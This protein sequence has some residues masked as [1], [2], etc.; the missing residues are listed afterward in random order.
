MKTSQADQWRKLADILD[1]IDRRGLRVLSAEE[2]L[3]LGRLYR[4]ASSELSYA[5]AH[6]L[7]P[8]ANTDLNRLV[9]RAYGHI[10]RAEKHGFAAIPRFFLRDF[11][12]AVRALWPFIAGA[13]ALSLV[14]GALAFLL[15]WFN[16]HLV[17][18]IL[19]SGFEQ[20]IGRII[21]RSQTP[22]DWLPFSMRPSAS[23]GIM[24]NNIGVAFFAFSGGI[25]LGLG[26]IYVLIFNGLM[27]GAVAAAV[28]RAG[29]SLS[30]WSFVAPHGVIELPAIFIAG[31]AGLLLGYT[32]INPG[33][34]T[35]K[36][37]LKLAA[38]RAAVLLGGV[39]A[40]LIVAGT[41][42]AFFSPTLTPAPIKLLF[43]AGVA[44][45]LTLYLF[46]MPLKQA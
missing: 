32:L 43:A 16:P 30:F 24:T 20:A 5:R 18:A 9:G 6:G 14:T 29:V 17:G 13:T 4:R 39:V 7:D 22:Q 15:I 8:R 1:R 46:V 2:L 26:T 11:P 10:Y 3:E 27:L 42:E 21:A 40:M 12:Q 23:A 36:T 38:R 37:A 35:R 25:L 31:G 33:D 19:P 45:S 41:I 34:Y 28:A 44:F